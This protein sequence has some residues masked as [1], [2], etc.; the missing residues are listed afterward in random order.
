MKIY[1][2]KFGEIF[3]K[4]QHSCILAMSEGINHLAVHIVS[5][6]IRLNHGCFTPDGGTWLSSPSGGRKAHYNLIAPNK[7]DITIDIQKSFGRIDRISLVNVSFFHSAT[8]W[9][10]IISEK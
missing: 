7:Y 1:S 8:I 10:K 5:G 4:G 3:L 2:E 6:K 9:Y